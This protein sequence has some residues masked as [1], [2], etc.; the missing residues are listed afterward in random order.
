MNMKFWLLLGCTV[1]LSSQAAGALLSRT[2]A[3]QAN[4]FQRSQG[5]SGEPLADP[6]LLN[7]SVTFDDAT[8]VGKTQAGLT[9]NSFN[10]P[11]P[12][13][14]AYNHASG[15]LSVGTEAGL[16]GC[17]LPEN[18]FCFVIDRA[19]SAAPSIDTVFQVT[20]T[21]TFFTRDV[22]LGVIGGG[23]PEPA[24]WAMML[25]GFGLIG[26]AMRGRTR[27]TCASFEPAKNRRA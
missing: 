15:S 19:S 5:G 22:R 27:M 3:V 7:F 2:Y 25:G 20:P 24:T 21:G 26:A 18:S 12:A 11:Y 4:G 16:R 13:F 9:V 1:F 10:L 23:I 8:T 14:Y 17:G 6:F